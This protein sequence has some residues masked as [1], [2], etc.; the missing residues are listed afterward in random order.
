MLKLVT[1]KKEGFDEGKRMDCSWKD[2][3]GAGHPRVGD[4]RMGLW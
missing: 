4:G 1:I 2:F 3:F